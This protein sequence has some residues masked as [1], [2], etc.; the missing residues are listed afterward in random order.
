[1]LRDLV[2]PYVVSRPDP[3]QAVLQ[4]SGDQAMTLA[5]RAL[6]HDPAFQRLEASWRSLR[7]LA[8]GIEVQEALSIFLLDLTQEELLL[9]LGGQEVRDSQ[10]QALLMDA[11]PSGG[12][13][14]S[15]VV[16]DFEFGQTVD[17]LVALGRLGAMAAQAGGLVLGAASPRLL[18]VA[19]LVDRTDPREWTGPPTDCTAV[20]D[21]LRTSAVAP[22]IGLALP[23]LLLRLPYGT[24]TDP[25]ERFGFE[26][27]G[28]S[29]AHAN[30]LW[31][32]PAYGLARLLGRSFARSGWAFQPGEI[33]ELDGLPAHVLRSSD[34]SRA[35]Q[36]VAE[37]FLSERAGEALL[38]RGFMPFLSLKNR[39]AAWLP[40][41]QSI[42]SPPR[43]LSG[44][45]E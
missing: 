21:E 23:R 29:P 11:D 7:K 38:A 36:A 4:E 33:Q 30:Y 12:R 28:P 2:A 22:F 13:P 1:L 27:L 44:P 5:M 9:D 14:F 45:W 34:G 32:N 19:S 41:M 18:G 35:L 17:D 26:E 40:R 42:A 6:L 24:A 20:W 25:T 31:G 37:V 16:A 10:L 15:L 3:G 8:G 43:A 39:N